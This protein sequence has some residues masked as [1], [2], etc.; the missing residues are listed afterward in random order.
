[1]SCAAEVR[2]G[3]G[4][5]RELRSSAALVGVSYGD[6]PGRG[7]GRT[8]SRT[9]RGTARSILSRRLGGQLAAGRPRGRLAAPLL[10][11]SRQG[12]GVLEQLVG[13]GIGCISSVLN[14]D[15]S[16]YIGDLAG[17]AVR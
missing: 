17:F 15:R 5:G 8:I 4:S 12:F 14:S 13:C 3:S 1:M 2:E 11:S 10:P 6:D 16:L 9:G 7:R